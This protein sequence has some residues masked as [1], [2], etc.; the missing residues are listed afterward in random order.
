MQGE[1]SEEQNRKT[2]GIYIRTLRSEKGW[3]I[4]DVGERIG[5]S[6]N[7]VSMLER[8]V[9]QPTD[10]TIEKFAE[11]FSVAE[12]QLY[13][14]IGRIPKSV[15]DEIGKCKRLQ[16]ALSYACKKNLSTDKLKQLEDKLVKVYAD[17]F[18]VDEK[19]F[20]NWESAST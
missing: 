13:H 4:H 20:E 7:Y 18:D 17:F 16:V 15:L 5:V 9:R 10:E 12:E 1:Q 11:L 3:S 2:F 19:I 6:S 8:G 14:I